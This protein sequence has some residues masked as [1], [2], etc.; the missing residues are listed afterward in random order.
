[1]SSR[2]SDRNALLQQQLGC[3]NRWIGVETLLHSIVLQDVAERHKAHTLMVGHKGANHNP[4]LI[5][6]QTFGRIVDRFIKPE[7]PERSFSLQAMQVL[8]RRQWI[9]LGCEHCRVRSYYQILNQS[10]LQSQTLDAQWTILIIQLNVAGVVGS[11]GYAPWH[12][13]FLTI[14]NLS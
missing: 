5:L 6:R 9:N 7:G 3:L 2:N 8:H 12:A 13:A 14:L 10:A 1:M 11:F 4:F